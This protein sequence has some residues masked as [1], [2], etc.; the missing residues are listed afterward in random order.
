M[1]EVFLNNLSIT[2]LEE[3]IQGTEPN[4]SD[5]RVLETGEYGLLTIVKLIGKI[6]P[7]SILDETYVEDGIIYDGSTFN[8]FVRYKFKDS[9]VEFQHNPEFDKDKEERDEKT[10]YPL[11]SMKLKRV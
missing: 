11:Q 9:I 6:Y 10:S 1:N 2:E 5:I 7:P 4:T 8:Q 3:F